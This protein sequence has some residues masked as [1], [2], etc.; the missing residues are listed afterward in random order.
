MLCSCIGSRE[1]Q[2]LSSGKVF[3]T[4][5]AGGRRN[6]TIL[7]SPP[8]R[9]I[10]LYQQDSLVVS[11]PIHFADLGR[12]RLLLPRFSLLGR[13]LNAAQNVFLSDII[14]TFSV[15][16]RTSTL[17]YIIQ[18]SILKYKDIPRIKY[19]NSYQVRIQPIFRYKRYI[20]YIHIYLQRPYSHNKLRETGNG[21]ECVK[22]GPLCLTMLSGTRAGGG[23][24]IFPLFRTAAYSVCIV[25]LS[26]ASWLCFII[27]DR[28]RS[29]FQTGTRLKL[30]Q[31]AIYVRHTGPVC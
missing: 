13:I 31:S 15:C 19:L 16:I 3:S 9:I 21:G 23:P 4:S 25:N 30:H 12:C 26:L 27:G 6:D 14:S 2:L 1:E 11:G 7:T 22:P 10:N 24:L 17:W 5:A 20:G 18:I 29:F 8:S 28:I